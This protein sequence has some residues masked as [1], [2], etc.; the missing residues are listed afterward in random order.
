MR[1]AS[2]VEEH[3]T[4]DSTNDRAKALAK[5]GAAHGLAV[6]AREQTKGRG[7]RGRTW[8]SPPAIG[9]YVSYL[10]RPR[11][12]LSIAQLLPL[13]SGLAVHRALRGLPLAIKWPNDLLVSA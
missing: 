8:V 4:I 12:A 2:I 10:V 7:Q 6:V 3:A 1:I 13:M 5:M 9:L 11:I